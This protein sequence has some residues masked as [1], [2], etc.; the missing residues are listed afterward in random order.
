MRHG[1]VIHDQS[2]QVAHFVIQGTQVLEKAEVLKDFES[3]SD[4]VTVL[5]DLGHRFD[6]L[7]VLANRRCES[8]E[9]AHVVEELLVNLRLL[10]PD[11]QLALV[12]VV[13]RELSRHER[14]LPLAKL[15]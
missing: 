5:H 10:H 14:A 9:H 3:H 13:L 8:V 6:L 4:A 7:R 11:P 2:Q 15:R 1:L 12:V